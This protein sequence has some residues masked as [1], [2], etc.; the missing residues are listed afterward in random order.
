MGRPKKEPPKAFHFTEL[1]AYFHA[2]QDLEGSMA[3]KHTAVMARGKQY[4]SIAAAF[5]AL[6]LP[7]ARHQLFRKKL[8]EEK[9]AEFEGIMFT[10]VE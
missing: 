7:M 10:V 9:S 2:I 5:M 3:N 8:K 4:K 1:Q 6:G